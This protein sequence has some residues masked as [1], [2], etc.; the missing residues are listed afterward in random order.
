MSEALS[1]S[2]ISLGNSGISSGNSDSELS[3][4]DGGL[5]WHIY[6]DDQTAIIRYYPYFSHDPSSN[7]CT[8]RQLDPRF[9]PVSVYIIFLW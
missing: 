9:R 4:V 1:N 3:A 5:L 6:G 2:W 7:V 8:K